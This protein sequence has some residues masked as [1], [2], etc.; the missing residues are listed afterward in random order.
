MSRRAFASIQ[1]V[2][3]VLLVLPEVAS[4]QSYDVERSL[5]RAV[6]GR[7][8]FDALLAVEKLS[9]EGML[10]PDVLACLEVFGHEALVADPASSLE[11]ARWTLLRIARSLRL[12]PDAYARCA[13]FSLPGVELNPGRSQ[14]IEEVLPEFERAVLQ[15]QDSSNSSRDHDPVFREELERLQQRLVFLPGAWERVDELHQM[16]PRPPPP[17]PETTYAPALVSA[18]VSILGAGYGALAAL[19]VSASDGIIHRSG[20][21]SLGLSV[22]LILTLPGAWAWQNPSPPILRLAGV[23][24]G[25]SVLSGALVVALGEGNQ[26]AFGE[27][28]LI[29]SAVNLL[30][31]GIAILRHDD[32]RAETRRRRR[33]SL[34]A[35]SMEGG[36]GILGVGRF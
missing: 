33:L 14:H 25:M 13:S 24:I 17:G 6:A 34:S 26:R 32:A 36:G 21:T 11:Q 8:A 35:W 20:A 1:I 10:R 27:G 18:G 4:A 12:L 22:G 29:G 3:V 31:L 2:A 23:L 28:M 30:W 7:V 15:V 19:S 5:A 16:L 9:E